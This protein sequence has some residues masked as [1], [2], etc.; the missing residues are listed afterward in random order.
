MGLKRVSWLNT[1]AL[2]VFALA[3]SSEALAAPASQ[4]QNTVG[5][6]LFLAWAIAYLTRR[7]A[8]GGWLLY[9]YI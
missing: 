2:G 4:G 5:A 3:I 9:F 6:G 7:R 1:I 8:I